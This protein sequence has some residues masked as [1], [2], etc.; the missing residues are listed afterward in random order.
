M[1][2]ASQTDP[3]DPDIRVAIA[4]LLMDQEEWG[5]AREYGR[6]L[7]ELNPAAPGSQRLLN[8]IQI[9]QLRAR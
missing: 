2:A 7:L 1:V 9:H 6:A 4:R 8:E 3:R 5:R